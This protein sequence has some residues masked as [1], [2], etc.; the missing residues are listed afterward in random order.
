M[1]TVEDMAKGLNCC[2]FAV[3]KMYVCVTNEILPS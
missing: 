3:S 2:L 1:A